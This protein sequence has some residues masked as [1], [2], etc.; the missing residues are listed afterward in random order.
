M[1]RVATMPSRLLAD[2]VV[3]L[4][5]DPRDDRIVG[6]EFAPLSHRS[7]HFNVGIKS[8]SCS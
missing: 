8:S 1:I 7:E 6:R 5:S 2:R 3:D 4:F